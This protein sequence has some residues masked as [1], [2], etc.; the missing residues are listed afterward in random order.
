MSAF[1]LHKGNLSRSDL[2]RNT[3]ASL[4]KYLHQWG[5]TTPATTTWGSLT[6]GWDASLRFI[7]RNIILQQECGPSLSESSKPWTPPP[8]EPPQEIPQ[9]ATSPGFP[10]SSSS[11]L[12]NN[13]RAV[14]TPPSTISVSRPSNS[15]LYS[16]PTTPQRRPTP[17]LLR[18]T[19]STSFSQPRR[20][21]SRGD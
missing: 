20:A 3:S 9:S 12:A 18:P 7:R 1:Y 14:P 11:G 4:A 21:E 8:R 13:A 17:C 10:S 16:S 19:F 2:S 6:F 5:P 15:L